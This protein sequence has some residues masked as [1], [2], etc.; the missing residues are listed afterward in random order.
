MPR[1]SVTERIA[2]ILQ[3]IERIQRYVQDM[4]YEDF[5]ASTITVDAVVRNL[6]I[7]GEA[8]NQVPAEVKGSHPELPWQKMVDMRNFI[9]HVYWQTDLSLVWD[10]IE[11][12]L[13][14]LHESLRRW[15][16]H[17]T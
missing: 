9:T 2:D 10:T 8:A 4:D 14:P 7:I 6:I 12:H 17:R 15:Q 11:H 16:E 5:C 13:P 1:R 3:A